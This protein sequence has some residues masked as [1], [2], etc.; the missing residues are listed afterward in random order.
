MM[1]RLLAATA[2][3][4]LGW[5]GSA[6]AT[7]ITYIETATGSGALNGAS[8][9]DKLVTVRFFGDTSNVAP[10]DP[11]NCPSCLVNFPAFSATVNVAG[12]GTDTFVDPVGI[13][14]I[15][16]MFPDFGNRAGVVFVDAAPATSG[17]TIL[18]TA[19]NALLG[20]D[21]VS[22]IGPISGDV[23]FTDAVFATTLGSFRW[24]PSPETSTFTVT[25]SA[26]PEPGSLVLLGM[27]LIGAATRRRRTRK[28]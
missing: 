23:V 4:L 15:P 7:P 14:G 8:F 3:V 19:S 25:A 5:A 16:V 10:F 2:I 26:V 11:V 21:L 6:Q 22:P 1:K 27:G 13:I 24:R 20:Y 9:T 17:L 12:V 28:A 18:I